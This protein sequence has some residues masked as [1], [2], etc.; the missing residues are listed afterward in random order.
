M[1]S[2]HRYRLAVV[3]EGG[4]KKRRKKKREKKR[5]KNLESVDPSP[6]APAQSC[7]RFLLPA[8]GEE[9]SPYVG[10]R[11]EA[12]LPVFIFFNFIVILY[13]TKWYTLCTAWYG[14]LYHTELSSV[15]RYGPVKLGCWI[16]LPWVYKACLSSHR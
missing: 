10:R 6:A 11:N 1:N 15:C 8:C 5:K 3:A 14:V 12:T 13:Y 16:G 2:V 7:G 4:R 9:T